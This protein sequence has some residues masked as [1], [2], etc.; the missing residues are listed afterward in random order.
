MPDQEIDINHAGLTIAQR[1]A[2]LAPGERAYALL[3]DGAKIEIVGVVP[4]NGATRQQRR[5]KKREDQ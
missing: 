2:L 3:P 4:N 5:T 1:R